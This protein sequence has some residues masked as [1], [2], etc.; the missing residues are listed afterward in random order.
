MGT[1]V[2]PN[3]NFKFTKL[4]ILTKPKHQIYANQHYTAL[5]SL[6]KTYP[7]CPRKMYLNPVQSL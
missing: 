1:T 4:N 2:V 3:Y 5:Y 6:W 7:S